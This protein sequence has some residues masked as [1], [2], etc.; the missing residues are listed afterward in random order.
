[1]LL[2]GIKV[3]DLSRFISGPYSGM[4]LGDMGADV[5]KVEKKGMGDDSRLLPPHYK[6]ESL[7]YFV[8]NRNK[9]SIS[10]D[11]RSEEGKRIIFQLASRADVIIENFRPGT[12]EKIG[13]SYE[14]LEKV[15]PKVIMASISGFGSD[16]PYVD[17]PGFDAAVQAMS[18]IM[19]ITGQPDSPPTMSGVFMVDYAAAM[20][21]TT[22]ILGALYGRLS[23]G[24]GQH[25]EISLLDCGVSLLLTAIQKELV[26]GE[27]MTRVGNRDRQVAPGNVFKTKDCQWLMIVAGSEVHFARL[28]KAMQREDLLH[29]SRFCDAEIRLKNAEEIEEIV[30][31]WVMEHDIDEAIEILEGVGVV[32]SKVATITDVVNNPQLKYRKKIIKVKHEKL[33]EIPMFEMPCNFSDMPFKLRYAPPQ[34]GEHNEEVLSEWLNLSKDE[35]ENY[36]SKGILYGGVA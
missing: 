26:L 34:L 32:C 18:G 25:L 9:R 5:V 20:Y 16:G 28:V 27:T 12:I 14:E 2:D 22:A 11:Y 33:G 30:Q 8:M 3:L 6:G 24:K 31:K 15:N 1:M 19:S 21:T 10:L 13:C 36:K 29:D 35:I 4:M 7:Y 23:T 17:K